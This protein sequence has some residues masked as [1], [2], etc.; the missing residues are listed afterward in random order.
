[1]LDLRTY[2]VTRDAVPRRPECRCGAAAVK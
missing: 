1:V 2:A